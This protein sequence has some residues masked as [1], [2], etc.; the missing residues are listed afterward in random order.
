MRLLKLISLIFVALAL[1]CASSTQASPTKRI[2]KYRFYG[3]E[4]HHQIRT[5]LTPSQK[6]AHEGKEP[7]PASLTKIIIINQP[8]SGDFLL[9]LI[10]HPKDK[11]RRR[12]INAFIQTWDT[13]NLQQID[14]YIHR[15]VELKIQN[16]PSYPQGT[17]AAVG[18]EYSA[19]DGWGG[20]PSKKDLKLKVQTNT[21]LDGKSYGEPYSD[22]GP[23]SHISPVF[24]HDLNRGKHLIKLV[25]G[26]EFTYQD[27]TYHGQLKSQRQHFRIVKDTGTDELKAPLNSELEAKVRASFYVGNT[28]HQIK[29]QLPPSA[30]YPFSLDDEPEQKSTMW[31]IKTK[32][33]SSAYCP[34][35]AIIPGVPVDM[36]F[37]VKI[38]D[39]S[40]GKIYD[41]API[42]VR[43]GTKT[44]GYF[45]PEDLLNFANGRTG[46]IPIKVTLTP[47]RA[48]ALTRTWA[49]QYY[50]KKLTFDGLQ[51]KVTS[52]NWKPPKKG[53]K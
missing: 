37:D 15:A 17:R 16:R 42:I 35:W 10:G 51:I 4:L 32:K 21:F 40:T 36:L 41:A 13:M 3:G 33:Q 1:Q 48:R 31:N 26:Y 18:L 2:N 29:M 24:L 53:V 9:D 14:G 34:F 46:T 8:Q 25:G 22:T 43:K 47:S 12:A 39:V 45:D 11:L 7:L 49:T 23:V 27:I 5:L 19:V 28:P 44:M 52:E 30:T 6:L 38:Q 20:W 50:P